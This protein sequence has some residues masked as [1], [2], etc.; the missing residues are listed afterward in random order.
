MDSL[1]TATRWTSVARSLTAR[2]LFPTFQIDLAGLLIENRSGNGDFMF[3]T[4]SMYV[5]GN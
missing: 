4:E 5:N 2:A 3:E 1:S